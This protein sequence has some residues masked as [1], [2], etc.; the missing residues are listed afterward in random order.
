MFAFVFFWNK[1]RTLCVLN[2]DHLVLGNVS[3]IIYKTYN[4]TY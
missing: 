4:I 2:N 3:D 1:W